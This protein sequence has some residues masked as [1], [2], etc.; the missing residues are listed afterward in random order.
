MLYINK[1][2]MMNRKSNKLGMFIAKQ[3]S[4]ACWNFGAAN[5]QV[6]YSS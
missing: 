3:F 5:V 1:I 4:D 2:I 6:Y